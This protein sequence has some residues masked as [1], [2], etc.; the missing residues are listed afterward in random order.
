MSAPV[1]HSA[2]PHHRRLR[3]GERVDRQEN[4]AAGAGF[5]RAAREPAAA[6]LRASDQI[7]ICNLPGGAALTGAR[8]PITNVGQVG[9]S[10]HPAQKR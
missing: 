1:Q 9:R 7:V 3:A 8:R 5:R 10:R 4:P 2:N 6:S